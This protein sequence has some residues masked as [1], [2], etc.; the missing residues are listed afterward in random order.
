MIKYVAFA[1]LGLNLILA[2]SMW[3]RPPMALLFAGYAVADCAAVWM[4]LT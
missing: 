1:K 2:I 3:Q 4:M